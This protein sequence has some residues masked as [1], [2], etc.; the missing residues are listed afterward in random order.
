L[1]NART[2]TEIADALE[3]VQVTLDVLVAHLGLSEQVQAAL[4][5]K[6]AKAER[7]RLEIER[8]L[9][10]GLDAGGRSDEVGSD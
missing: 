2:T 7:S 6:Q 5:S 3:E 8:S 4:L 10:H 1:K 9:G